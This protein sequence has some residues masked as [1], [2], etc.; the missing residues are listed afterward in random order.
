[1]RFTQGHSASQWQNKNRS[2]LCIS[3]LGS[4]WFTPQHFSSGQTGNA[5]KPSHSLWESRRLTLGIVLESG[6]PAPPLLC[7]LCNLFRVQD[8]TQVKTTHKLPSDTPHSS[9]PLIL[10]M[11]YS[12]AKILNNSD[13]RWNNFSDY[14]LVIEGNFVFY[15]GILEA[16]A[17]K[18]D[19]G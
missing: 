17:F 14:V 6:C 13:W 10:Q 11:N 2:I 4:C 12:C 3:P 19:A 1:M 16:K 9:S 15:R 5:K 18:R 8:L 7:C